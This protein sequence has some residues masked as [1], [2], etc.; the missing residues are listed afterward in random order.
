MNVDF[1]KTYKPQQELSVLAL[2]SQNN[3]TNN[4]VADIFD[5]PA[6]LLLVPDDQE[7]LTLQ[8]R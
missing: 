4:F 1:T 6:G 3:R 2:F 8:A 7:R 5:S